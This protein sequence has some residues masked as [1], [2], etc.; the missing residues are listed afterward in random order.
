MGVDFWRGLVIAVVVVIAALSVP[1]MFG[2]KNANGGDGTKWETHGICTHSK[3]AVIEGHRYV[4]AR[5][6]YGIAIVHAESCGC[7]R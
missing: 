1:L 4:L 5:S 2:Y 6:G 3:V 7:K